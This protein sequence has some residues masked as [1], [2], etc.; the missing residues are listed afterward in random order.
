MGPNG[1][2]AR[3]PSI[4]LV[5]DN[6]ANLRLLQDMLGA[7][8]YRLR[9]VLQGK[10][11]L[12]AARSA[13]PDLV[14]LDINM[15]DLNGYQ[16][17]EQLKSDPELSE[18][19][20]IFLSAMNDV[21][22]KIKAFSA[23]GVDYITKPFQIE[24]VIARVQTHIELRQKRRELKESFEALKRS[25][26][27]R[28]SLTH[29]IVHDLRAPLQLITFYLDFEKAEPSPANVAKCQDAVN[30][31]IEMINVMLDVGKLES[32]NMLLNRSHCELRGLVQKVA[33]DCCPM[34]D[35]AVEVSAPDDPVTIMIDCQLIYRVIQN[36]LTNAIRFAKTGSPIRITVSQTDESVRV[37]VIDD[38]PGIPLEYQEKIFEK[39]G[40]VEQNAKYGTGLGL[41]FC[42]LAI[43][44]HGGHIGV[45]SETGKGSRFWFTL[46]TVKQTELAAT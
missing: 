4:L 11:A 39:Y 25:D 42:K 36:L 8:G 7:K 9:P 45:V 34:N 37:E 24:E 16:V 22:D 29:M 10:L 40:Q 44:L 18:I 32:R 38:G 27:L 35:G 17:C 28:E 1:H 43:E 23:G 2:I 20:V 12:T 6:P 33:D 3:A 26:D 21:H 13:T 46:P 5:D 30:Q 14:L 41:T 19:P 15:P 31:I